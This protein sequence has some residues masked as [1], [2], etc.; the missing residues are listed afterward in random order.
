MS[1]NLTKALPQDFTY[2]LGLTTR[3]PDIQVL[4][5]NS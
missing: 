3:V 1:M 2:V 5:L 4:P